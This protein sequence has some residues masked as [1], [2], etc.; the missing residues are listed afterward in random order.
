MAK[1]VATHGARGVAAGQQLRIEEG[2]GRRGE[3]VEEGV[4]AAATI[5][6]EHGVSRRNA[7]QG[8]GEYCKLPVLFQ[9]LSPGSCG[10]K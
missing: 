4:K 3:H 5:G 7:V 9:E 8:Q 2:A 1:F 6:E 10:L